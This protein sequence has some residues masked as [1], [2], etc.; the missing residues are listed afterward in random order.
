MSKS[1][2]GEHQIMKI[3]GHNNINSIESYLQISSGSQQKDRRANEKQQYKHDY[4]G[5]IYVYIM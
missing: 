2:V 5:N 3:T 1:G 4:R